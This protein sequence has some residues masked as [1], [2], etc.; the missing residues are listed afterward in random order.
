M[1]DDKLQ[2]VG[3]RHKRQ[4]AAL[5]ATAAELAPLIRAARRQSDP[6]TLRQL[7]TLTGLSYARIHQIEKGADG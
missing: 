5:E 7:A 2:E 1:I 3:R 4:R 6:P